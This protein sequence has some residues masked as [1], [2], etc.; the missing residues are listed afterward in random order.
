[1]VTAKKGWY[2][3]IPHNNDVKFNNFES[4]NRKGGRSIE[5]PLAT[6]GN[7][8]IGNLLCLEIC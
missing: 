3:T 8:I 4:V 6:E 5:H 2:D 1:M 7:S